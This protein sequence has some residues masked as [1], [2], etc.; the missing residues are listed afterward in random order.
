MNTQQNKVLELLKSRGYLGV[1]SYDLTYVH[2]IKQAPTRI[3]EL[4]EKN[5]VIISR[6]EKNRSVTYILVASPISPEIIATMP[7][8]D[9]YVYIYEGNRAKQVKKS[10][11]IQQQ[12]LL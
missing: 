4:K 6:R 12:S 2:S 1:N 11:L 8:K 7:N 3:S 10:E 9:E 5:H